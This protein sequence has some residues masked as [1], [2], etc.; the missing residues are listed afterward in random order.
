MKQFI[1]LIFCILPLSAFAQS[2][3]YPIHPPITKQDVDVANDSLLAVFSGQTT[4]LSNDAGN[5]WKTFD[6]LPH[7]VAGPFNGYFSIKVFAPAILEVWGSSVDTSPNPHLYPSHGVEMR[8]LDSGKTWSYKQLGSDPY[9]G[10]HYAVLGHTPGRW[11]YGLHYNRAN[12]GYASVYDGSSGGLL[13]SN[14][15]QDNEGNLIEN[16]QMRDGSV[17]MGVLV[18]GYPLKTSLLVTTNGGLDWRT[19][20]ISIPDTVNGNL[21]LFSIVHPGP[22]QDWLVTNIADLFISHDTGNSWQQLFHFPNPISEFQF[23]DS[24]GYVVLLGADY[25]EKTTDGGRTWHAQSCSN[26]SSP[27][28]TVVPTSRNV[29]YAWANGSFTYGSGNDGS[30]IMRTSDGKT[31]AAPVMSFTRVVPFGLLPADSLATIPISAHNVGSDTLTVSGFISDSANVTVTPSKFKLAPGDSTSV[32]VQYSTHNA[33]WENIRVRF[34]ANTVPQFEIFHV[35]GKAKE[36]AS[37]KNASAMPPSL[38][39]QLTN[40]PWS[41]T[42]TLAIDKAP[43][44]EVT[45]HIY[46][47]LGT[48]RFGTKTTANGIRLNAGDFPTGFYTVQVTET[49]GGRTMLKF[50]KL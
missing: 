11:V 35:T 40:N 28:T 20:N 30:D 5:T 12:P 36:Q 1:A 19:A 31:I 4:S 8:S 41:T 6:S 48:E 45:I 17:G 9:V 18:G 22:A 37:V 25:I 29:A 42:T 14:G 33:A 43:N 46:D 49:T 24:V 7:V 47:I 32:S 27:V 44:A 50:V 16:L 26:G 39:A 2:G 21:S 38:N 23:F 10:L 13:Y 3:W 34:Q 15:V